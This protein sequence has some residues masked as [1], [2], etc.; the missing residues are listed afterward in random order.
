LFLLYNTFYQFATAKMMAVTSH[1]GVTPA[2]CRKQ[3]AG[4][5]TRRKNA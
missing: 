4:N 2:K 1:A 5:K 3:N